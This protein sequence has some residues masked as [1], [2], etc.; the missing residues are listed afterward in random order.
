[1]LCYWASNIRALLYWV[2]DDDHSF[3][4]V[5]LEQLSVNR[6]SLFGYWLGRGCSGLDGLGLFTDPA[7]IVVRYNF[8]FNEKTLM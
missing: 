1:M 7:V 3:S 2:K 8:M 6:C 5:T 4:W